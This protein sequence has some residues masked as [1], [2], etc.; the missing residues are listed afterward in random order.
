MQSFRSATRESL[1]LAVALLALIA[2]VLWAFWPAL[3]GPFLFDDYSNLSLLKVIDGEINAE[4]LRTYFMAGN[5]GPTG[6]PISLLSFL[7]ND[8]TWPSSAE[9]FKYTN[10]LLHLINGLLLCWLTFL[11]LLRN[12]KG[13]AETTFYIALLMAAFWLLNPYQMSSVM[14]VV[15]RM[16]LL[17]TF[18]VLSGLVIYVKARYVMQQ[19]RVV[20]G[21][22]LILLAYFWGALVGALAKENAAIFVLLVPLIE[23]FFFTNKSERK[24]WQLSFIIWAPFVFFFVLLFLQWPS[25]KIEYE[26]IRDFTLQ[27]RLLSE[28]RAVGYYLWR[29]L[30][31]GVGYV[32]VLADGFDKSVDL[33]TPISTFFF[34]LLHATLVMSAVWL[35][36]RL[37]LFS[38]GVL[39]FYVAHSLEST[40]I[41]LELM[42]E[43][44]NYLP[45]AFLVLGL[46][47]FPWKKTLFLTGIGVV[48][49]C[50]FLTHVQARFWSDEHDLKAIMVSENPTSERAAL[51]FADYVQRR[52]GNKAALEMLDRYALSND[53]GIEM[54][55]NIIKLRCLTGTDD[56]EAFKALKDSVHTYRGKMAYLV[57]RAIELSGVVLSGS[58]QYLD[59]DKLQEFLDAYYVAWP[60]N[61]MS[62]QSYLVASAHVQLVGGDY[63]GFKHTMYE[64]LEVLDNPEL[65]LNLCGWFDSVGQKEDACY[66]FSSQQPSQEKVRD[67]ERNKLRRFYGYSK[68]VHGRFADGI[69]RSCT[70]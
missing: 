53:V 50:V 58:C 61:D 34:L 4:S 42:F 7:L 14:Y 37:P 49:L 44:R 21:Y 67:L 23:F 59:L 66:C 20:F 22:F 63:D 2:A 15:Q 28:G 10:L 5:T 8:F 29:Y 39:F 56:E 33:F 17:A 31:P 26:L 55:T 32:G 16:A 3:Q 30:I 62:D 54:A 68:K 11:L 12:K 57:S 69:D 6:R 43:H 45:S 9:S 64:A 46:A 48:L 70:E 27:E 52:M 13:S 24:P 41:P 35:R 19:G 25:Q 65:A 36:K 40:H 1:V 18:F 60:K 51:V 38:F 47:H